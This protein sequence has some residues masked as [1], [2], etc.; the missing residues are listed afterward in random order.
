M[1]LQW[2]LRAS[3]IPDSFTHTS[4][5]GPAQRCMSIAVTPLCCRVAHL[6]LTSCASR[7]FNRRMYVFSPSV[8]EN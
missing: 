3:E 6:V 2:E 7:T 4:I 5:H 1:S 8:M